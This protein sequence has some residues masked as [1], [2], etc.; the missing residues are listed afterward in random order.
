M[1]KELT[2]YIVRHIF[3]NLGIIESN[4]INTNLSKSL[5]SQDFLLNEKLIFEDELGV[6]HENKIYGCQISTEK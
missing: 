5:K 4:Y 2:T 6:I 3:S 1:N